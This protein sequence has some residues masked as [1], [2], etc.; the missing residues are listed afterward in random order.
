MQRLNRCQKSNNKY[1]KIDMSNFSIIDIIVSV[2]TAIG[3]WEAIK[4]FI[5]RRTEK[6][7]A[8]AE[9]GSLETA[10]TKELQAIYQQLIADVKAD[11]NEQ[12]TYI[13]ELNEDRKHLREEREE[14]RQRIDDTEKKVMDL[15]REVA[16]NGRMVESLRPFICGDLRCRKRQP[17]TISENGGIE[18]KE[19]D[20]DIDP[21][22]NGEL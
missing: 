8:E 3:G 20:I 22:N 15:Q 16:R 13:N 18:N 2:L 10:A 5:N 17:V 12:R 1:S 7:K 4:Y 14:L 11:R 9:A 21:I 19:I 6:R